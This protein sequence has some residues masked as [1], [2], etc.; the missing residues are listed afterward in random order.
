MSEPNS[1]PNVVRFGVFEV[2]LRARELRKQGVKIRLQEQPFRILELLLETPGQ[3]VTR[4]E[5]REKLWSSDTHVDFDRG[6]NKAINKLREALAN[7]PDTP[8][9]VETLP[10][11]GYRFIAPLEEL[12]AIIPA[13]RASAARLLRVVAVSVLG[14]FVALIV[15]LNVDRLRDRLF[16][17]SA[18]GEISSLAVLPLENLSGDPQQDYFAEGMHEALITELGKIGAIRVISRTS[19]LLPFTSLLLQQEIRRRWSYLPDGK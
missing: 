2:D 14:V 3:I 7:S 4:D 8:R 17:R 15:V 16:G 13:R 5:I 1:S 18:P 10:R 6:L 12:G 9:Y 19:V 11:R